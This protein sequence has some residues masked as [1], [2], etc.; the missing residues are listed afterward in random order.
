V[1]G[2]KPKLV[3]LD[4]D[5]D[6]DLVLIVDGRL[7][8]VWSEKGSFSLDKT[9]LVDLGGVTETA[10]G[11]AVARDR[12]QVRLVAVSDQ[13]AYEV[14]VLPIGRRPV[15]GAISGI[16]PGEAVAL[17]DVT[18]DGLLDIVVAG[19]RGVQIFAEVPRP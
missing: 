13:A 18:G 17:G 11:F 9:S 8:V 2:S 6:A 14:E 5:G 12:G 1:R 4:G 7:G 10:K 15:A 3:D 16:G 19:A